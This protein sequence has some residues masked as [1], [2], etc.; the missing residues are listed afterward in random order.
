M[1]SMS[2]L[3]IVVFRKDRS[4]LG[5]CFA[6]FPELPADTAGNSCTAYQTIGQ[7]CAADYQGCVANSDPANPQEYADLHRELERRGY[8]LDIRKRATAAMRERR[9]W[10]AI[11][12]ST[13]REQPV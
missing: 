4:G 12:R 13:R 5:E 3:T 2:N 1:T 7:H 9:R 6:L 8:D 11:Q 10:L